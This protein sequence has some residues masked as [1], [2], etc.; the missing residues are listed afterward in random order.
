M[1]RIFIKIEKTKT[2]EAHWIALN[3]KSK[4]KTQIP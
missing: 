1:D 2:V 4:M 3:L